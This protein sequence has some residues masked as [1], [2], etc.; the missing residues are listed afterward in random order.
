MTAFFKN[1]KNL[2]KK[3]LAIFLV[4]GCLAS[5]IPLVYFSQNLTTF[6]VSHPRL[7]QV[8]E[9]IKGSIIT[10]R[11]MKESYFVDYHN[12]FSL[13]VRRNLEYPEEISLDFTVSQLRAEM[14][15]HQERR[16]LLYCIFDNAENKL[17]GA[18]EIREKNDR[19]PGQLGCWI[20]EKY[21]GKGRFQE[22]LDLISKTYFALTNAP[23]YI[24]HV[25]LWNKRSYNALKKYGLK[26]TG[27][28]YEHGEPTRY[29]LKLKRPW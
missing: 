8:P 21:W 12:M 17:I 18:L 20:N 27:F 29:I 26:D 1:I 24:A 11:T 15:A 9:E 7:T 10:L 2:N 4:L 16:M 5:C 23:D 19:D 6:F 13:D 14:K 3:K 25:R 22:A 28:Y